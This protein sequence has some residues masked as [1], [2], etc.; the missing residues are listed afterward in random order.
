MWALERGRII[1]PLFFINKVN[2]FVNLERR[3]TTLLTEKFS[4]PTFSDCYIIEINLKPKQKLLVFIDSDS[5]MTFKKCQQ[6]SRH[7]EAHL[8]ESLLLGEK[9][10]LE[11]SSPGIDRPLKLRRQYTKNLNRHLKVQV[12][13]LEKPLVGKLIAIDDESIT[14]ETTEKIKEGKKKKQI[15][16][17]HTLPFEKIQEAVVQVSF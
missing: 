12:E 8:D 16:V 14:L 9:Y 17:Q 7:L 2:E 13:A 1:H 10:T 15:T 4:E 6:I 11:V 5:G 3:I